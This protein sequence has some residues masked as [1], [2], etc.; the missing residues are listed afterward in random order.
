MRW[1]V[2]ILSKERNTKSEH[3]TYGPDDSQD[4]EEARS[5][6]EPGECGEVHVGDDE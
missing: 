1:N 3:R 2:R 6:L 5:L 4:V